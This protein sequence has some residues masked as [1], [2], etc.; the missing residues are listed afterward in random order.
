MKELKSL[1][2]TVIY[3][4]QVENNVRSTTNVFVVE[5]CQQQPHCLKGLKHYILKVST[6][7]FFLMYSVVYEA[8]RV[9]LLIIFELVQSIGSGGAFAPA[10]RS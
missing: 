10:V 3:V 5:R 4:P 8:D 2:R 6:K 9:Q 1:L 7:Q